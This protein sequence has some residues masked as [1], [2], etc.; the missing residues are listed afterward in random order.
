LGLVHHLGIRLDL[1]LLDPCLMWACL[2]ERIEHRNGHQRVPMPDG[3]GNCTFL[4]DIRREEIE[5]AV[6]RLMRY[7]VFDNSLFDTRKSNSESL[8]SNL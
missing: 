3:I 1:N 8:I 2:L 6:E 7:S 5:M 4:N